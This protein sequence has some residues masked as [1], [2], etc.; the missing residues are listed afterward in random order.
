[1]A[2]HQSQ[3]G[4]TPLFASSPPFYRVSLRGPEGER[5]LPVD[6]VKKELLS[7]PPTTWIDFSE[8]ELG[9]PPV[10]AIDLMR[11]MAPLNRKWIARANVRFIQ[12]SSRRRGRAAVAD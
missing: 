11:R 9:D 4:T 7:L 8:D 1:M 3:Q 5:R 2:E 6:I 12:N 10:Y